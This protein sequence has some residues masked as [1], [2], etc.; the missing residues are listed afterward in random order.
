MRIRI[1]SSDGILLWAGGRYMD[2]END[3]IMLEVQD[4]FIQVCNFLISLWKSG[5]VFIT[6]PFLVFIQLGDW[7]GTTGV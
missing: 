4:G 3:F 6:D 5:K 1:T 2:F 7:P